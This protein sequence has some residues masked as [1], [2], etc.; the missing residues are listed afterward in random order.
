MSFGTLNAI[1]LA[2]Y[3][4]ASVCY[5]A[6]VFLAT[7][8]APMSEKNRNVRANDDPDLENAR[9]LRWTGRVLLLL[10]ILFQFAATGVWCATMHRSPFA[11]EYGTLSVLAWIIAVTFA[12]IDLRRNLPAVGAIALPVA[13]VI[14]FWALLHVHGPVA[15]T[16]VLKSQIVSLHVLAILSSY[17][18][19]ALAFGCAALYLLQ[20]ALLKQR[21]VHSLFS[22]IPP[23]ASLDAIAYRSVAYALPLLTLGLGLGVAD[24]FSKDSGAPPS[25]WLLDAHTLASFGI[26]GLYVTY[27]GTRIGLG[28]R[29]VRPQYLLLVGLVVAIA[30][31]AIPSA[32]HSFNSLSPVSAPSS[33]TRLQT[34]KRYS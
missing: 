15:D 29:G 19:F 22:S 1:A 12:L 7:P 18:L 2:F 28:W 32:T 21:A 3:I 10:G 34:P 17:G 31:Y 9:S 27:L 6:F 4:L 23:L 11:S 30:L 33:H 8:A 5:G 14:L 25:R 24:I 16:A 13:C 26:W 20:N